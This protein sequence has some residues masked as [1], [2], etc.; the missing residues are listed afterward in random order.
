MTGV[1][2]S[3]CLCHVGHILRTSEQLFSDEVMTVVL[4]S[5]SIAV[6][7]LQQ[8]HCQHHHLSAMLQT[9]KALT[10]K[11]PAVRSGSTLHC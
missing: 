6:D 1:E 4:H 9:V 3:T 5:L 2:A 7:Q 8:L 10:A 11:Y